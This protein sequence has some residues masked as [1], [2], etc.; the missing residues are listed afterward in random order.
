ERG[1]RPPRGVAVGG[2][3]PA[4]WPEG[5]SQSAG[6]WAGRGASDRARAQSRPEDHMSPI[7]IGMNL[8]LAVLLLAAL[9]MGWRLNGRLKALRE[10]QAGFAKAVGE[11][12][13]AAARAE[14]GLA[15]LR[16]ATNETSDLLEDRIERARNLAAKLE[17]LVL[18]APRHEAPPAAEA[19]EAD[20][21][22]DLA[23]RE[24][25][26]GMLLAAAQQRR[27]RP[28][29]EP[30]PRAAAAIAPQTP[31]GARRPAVDDDLFDAPLTLGGGRR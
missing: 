6:G 24:R 13:A 31:S 17:R 4:A 29:P 26:F 3:S 1:P 22:L 8:M 16:A 28:A 10:S 27:G 21:V 23:E 25:R 12:N 9:A 19:A 30:A 7:A 15:D 18:S 2:G 20:E 5:A 11:L 14:Q